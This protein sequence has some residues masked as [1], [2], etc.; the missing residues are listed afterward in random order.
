MASQ[1]RPDGTTQPT[2]PMSS[3]STYLVGYMLVVVGLGIAAFLLNVEIVWI[4]VG[5][6]VLIGLGVVMATNRT[7]PRDPPAT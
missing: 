1:L 3:F 2:K 6:I 7:K 5:V 4:V